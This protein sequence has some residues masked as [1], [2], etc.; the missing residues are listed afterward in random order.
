M[1]EQQK[2]FIKREI[3]T[4][5]IAAAFQRASVYVDKKVDEKN[6]DLFKE[7]LIQ[8]ITNEILPKYKTSDKVTEEEHINNIKLVSNKS[9]KHSEILTNGHLNFGVS[10]KMLNLLLKYYWCMFDYPEPPH[11]PVDRRIQE[12]TDHKII[13]WTKIDNSDDYMKIINYL[14]SKAKTENKSIAKYELEHFE[15]RRTKM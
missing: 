7:E 3:W 9:K 14:R 8:Y 2:K 13:N 5:T 6:K 15:R 12:I 1:N 11:F 10:Q 4:L